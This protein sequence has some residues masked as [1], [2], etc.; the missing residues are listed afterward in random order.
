MISNT[1]K[2]KLKTTTKLNSLDHNSTTKN[3]NTKYYIKKR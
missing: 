1:R 2:G 3:K